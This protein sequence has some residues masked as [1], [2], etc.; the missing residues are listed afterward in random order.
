[1]LKKTIG[2]TALALSLVLGSLSPAFAQVGNYTQAINTRSDRGYLDYLSSYK[3]GQAHED[4]GVAEIVSY[5]PEKGYIY[6]VS[7]QTQLIDLVKVQAD[8]KTQLIKKI[9]LAQEEA[10]KDITIGDVTSVA[11]NSTYQGLA[12]A[13][14]EADYRKD[15]HIVL[16]DEEGNY[17]AHYPAGVQPDMVT[18]SP[19][20]RYVLTANEGEPREGYLEGED[21]K[22]SLTCLDLES[23]QAENIYFDDLSREEALEKGLV[24]KKDSQ[25]AQDLEP[26]YIAFSSDGKLAYVTLQENNGVGALDLEKKAWTY[27]K[28]LGFKD[29]SQEGMGLDLNRDKEI[30]IQKEEALGVYMPDGIDYVEIGQR[31]YLLTANEGDAREWGDEDV[32]GAFYTNVQEA[33]LFGAKKDVEYLINEASDGLGEGTYL[34][35]GRSFS[36]W[37]ADSLERVYDSGDEFEKITGRIFP[38]FFNSGHDEAA[39]EKRSNKKGP[40]PESVVTFKDGDKTYAVVGLERMGGIMVYDITNPQEAHYMDYLNVRKFVHEDEEPDLASLGDLGAEGIHVVSRE[41]SPTG[42]PLILVANE[43]SGTLTLAQW[44][45]GQEPSPDYLDSWAKDPIQLALDQGLMDS[46]AQGRFYPQEANRRIDLVVS[47]A[48]LEGVKAQDYAGESYKDLAV[49]SDHSG[50]V[51]WAKEKGLIQG[52]P[53]GTFRGNQGISRQ[54]MAKV[55]TAYV[56]KLGKDKPPVNKRVPYKDQGQ[57]GAWAL[58]EVG[59]VQERGLMVGRTDG[60][61]GPRDSLSRAE[62]AKILDN[63]MK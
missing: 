36:I 10:L 52:Y 9:N 47:L 48:K 29:H 7:G 5:N 11:Y 51:N 17:R 15:G 31:G 57:I 43:I 6:L 41:D 24:L 45:E 19:D 62:V 16:M 34:L 37:D 26:E 38:D 56:E 40:E 42:H 33:K 49:S 1:M 59:Q 25:P 23:G 28:G 60:S 54:E 12:I 61:F 4:G 13:V 58:E 8:G 14:Q 2:R 27:I 50:Y 3:T 21:P 53:D 35:G 30:R 46:D 18:F 55:L 39:L 63:L 44:L 20:G 22:G 32:E